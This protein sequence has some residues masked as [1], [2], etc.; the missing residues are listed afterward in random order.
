MATRR[1]IGAAALGALATFSTALS[2]SAEVPTFASSESP[3]VPGVDPVDFPAAGDVTGDGIDDLVQLVISGSPTQNNSFAVRPGAPDGQLGAPVITTLPPDTSG[4]SEVIL[5]DLNGDARADLVLYETFCDQGFMCRFMQLPRQLGYRP[6]NSDGTF[7]AATLISTQQYDSR[8]MLGDLD[9]DGDL[10][11]VGITDVDGLSRHAWWQNTGG[12][13]GPTQLLDAPWGTLEGIGQLGGGAA[14]DVL[15]RTGDQTPQFTV[16]IDAG[17][18]TTT[19]V[20]TPASYPNVRGIG[21]MDGD[22]IDDLLVWQSFNWP[23]SFAIATGN[24]DGTFAAPATVPGLGTDEINQFALADVA[25]DGTFDIIWYDSIGFFAHDVT[26]VDPLG[27]DPPTVVQQLVDHV[28]AGIPV[29]GNFDGQGNNDVARYSYGYNGTTSRY[30]LVLFGLPDTTPPTVTVTAP[31]GTVTV[32]QNTALSAE[33]TC[34]DELG[35][36]G[37]ASCAINGAPSPAPLSTATLGTNTVTVTATDRDGNVGTATISYDVRLLTRPGATLGVTATTIGN[38]GATVAFNPP[39]DDGGLPITSYRATCTSTDGGVTRTASR[40]TSPITVTALTPSAT[41]TCTVRAT[42]S[43]GI[44]DTSQ[45]S[46]PFVLASLP[47]A[48][49]VTSVTVTG[50]GRV[51]VAYDAPAADGGSPISSYRVTCTPVDGGTAR[52]VTAATNPITVTGLL[53]GANYDCVARAINLSGAG[54]ASP[55]VAITIPA[56]PSPPTVTDVSITGARR[57]GVTFTPAPDVTNAPTLSFR[58]TC[59]SN[60]GGTT[61]TATGATSPLTVTTLTAGAT[62]TC[63]VTATNVSGTS[64]PSAPSSNLVVPAVPGRPVITG[65]AMSGALR[66]TVIY[67]PPASDGGTPITSYRTT[68]TSANGGVTRTAT[69]TT[70]SALVTGLTAGTSYTCS[71]TATNLSGTGLPSEPSVTVD[72][73][74][75]PSAPT[76]T[77]VSPSGV[78]RVNV[79]F[80][81]SASDGG[82]PIT[83]YRATCT[84]ADGGVTRTASRATS[85]ITVTTLTAGATYTCTVAGVN[86]SG[87]G[88]ASNPSDPFLVS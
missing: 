3:G 37:I 9:G 28:H 15:Y 40:A 59:T 54:P 10:D 67:N 84:S 49:T 17:T 73:P 82:S 60:D 32:G 18:A 30:H 11:V 5:G 45:P 88:S 48:P 65:A 44:G 85:P 35:G 69:S 81:P 74:A 41:Y 77:S 39:T 68:C 86:L 58:A 42:N 24:G 57:A 33:F 7:G 80:T 20:S 87:T 72:V 76:L 55:A 79:A 6:G 62:Y 4:S 75:T 12:S 36:S 14:A 23:W 22:Q 52:T 19:T 16:V 25:D 78:R 29:V 56:L 21:D 26:L 61:R 53:I 46:E 83:T 70:T 13:F 34:A 2:V 51:A 63:V 31:A 47:G 38:A 8:I 71:V 50:A 43:L 27:I 66:A 1:L 64:A